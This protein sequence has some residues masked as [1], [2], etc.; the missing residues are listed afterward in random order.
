MVDAFEIGECFLEM[1]LSLSL[2][3]ANICLYKL[4]VL[5]IPQLSSLFWAQHICIFFVCE[6]QLEVLQSNSVKV[7]TRFTFLFTI[8]INFQGGY[9]SLNRQEQLR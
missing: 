8:L 4:T 9:W 3:L 2:V 5:A 7:W 6:T 1:E